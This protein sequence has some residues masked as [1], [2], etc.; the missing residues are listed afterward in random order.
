MKKGI[1]LI[2]LAFFTFQLASAQYFT[3]SGYIKESK[4]AEPLTGVTITAQGH[5]NSTATNIAG[6]YSLRLPSGRYQVCA[7]F[8]GYETESVWLELCS[9]TTVHFI[10]AESSTLLD[11][12]VVT[13]GSKPVSV[14]EGG[15]IGVNMRQVRHAPAFLGEPDIIKYLQIMPGVSSGREG[16][17]Q[18]DVRGG[19]G[20]QTLILLDEVP[21][22]NQ[23]HAFGLLSIFNSDALSGAELFKGHIPARYGGRL[24]SVASMRMRD[25]NKNEHHQS[26]TLGTLSIGGLL[27]GPINQGKGSYLISARRF[28]PDLLLRGFYALNKEAT[29]E[30]LYSFY[31]VNAKVNYAL[32]NK[33]KVY[34]SFYNGGDAVAYNNFDY[35]AA[36][37]TAE[38]GYGLRWGNTSAS[39]RLET[40][41]A[42]N[43]FIHNSIYYSGIGNRHHSTYND[44]AG[45]I[46]SSSRISAQMYEAG[47]R[48]VVEQKAGI[49]HDLRY[50]I[51]V[52]YQFFSP[53]MTSLTENNLTTERG[54]ATNNLYTGSIFLDDRITFDKITLEAGMRASIF[55]NNTNV[56]WGIEPRLSV[57]AKVDDYN[58][59]HLSYTR[60]LQP[61]ISILKPYLGFP[62]DFWIPYEGNT[63]SSSDQIS[64]GWSNTQFNNLTFNIEAYYKRLNIS[65]LFLL[66]MIISQENQ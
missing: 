20:D 17:S 8:I 58:N 41:A 43:I 2:A 23:N 40:Q 60:S 42:K 62:L 64:A 57:Q 45:D 14:K 66:P 47:L 21:I 16:S 39:L 29:W 34:A 27:E 46:H 22:F 44:I 51:H 24:S 55:Y 4:S 53:Q 30:L 61:L 10:L 35:D 15:N 37:K 56:V 49:R 36:G 38:C 54:F 1:L 28:T 25:G 5:A 18:L 48:S 9:D 6:F 65:P 31:D 52:N 12:A 11:A 3:L 32:G 13:A 63:I 33:N 26:I 19:G 59:T 7:S 50:G